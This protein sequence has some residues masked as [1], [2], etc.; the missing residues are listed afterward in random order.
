MIHHET[1][2]DFNDPRNPTDSE[3]R[4]EPTPPME[5]RKL[6]ETPTSAPLPASWSAYY[7]V[8]VIATLL[9][10]ITLFSTRRA[11]GDIT[12][13]PPAPR[14]LDSN[15]DGK[16]DEA[17]LALFTSWFEAG[18][19]R[20]DYDGDGFVTGEDHDQYTKEFSMT[21]GWSTYQLA[22]GAVEF[23]CNSD[24]EWKA[25]WS[26]ADPERGDHILLHAGGTFGSL[27]KIPFGGTISRPMLIGRYGDGPN[28]IVLCHG[29]E[30]GIECTGGGGAPPAYYLA[31][32]GIHFTTD[33]A[34]DQPAGGVVFIRAGRLDVE[35][36]QIE[37][38]SDNLNVRGPVSSPAKLRLHRSFIAGA[39]SRNGSHSQG[40]YVQD[41]ESAE[42]TENT[43][44]HNGWKDPADRTI[45]NHNLYAGTGTRRVVLRSNLSIAA[46]ATGLAAPYE[47][48]IE[49]NL[50]ADCPV[51]MFF[52]PGCSVIN[53]VVVGSGDIDAA[54]PRGM[55]MQLLSIHQAED[56]TYDGP[57]GPARIE[58]NIV[59]NK[60]PGT[61]G[62]GSAFIVNSNAD[63]IRC[64][65]YLTN[66]IGAAWP[67]EP[68][69]L[70]G[71]DVDPKSPPKGDADPISVDG[72]QYAGTAAPI[73]S[74]PDPS[75]NLDAY[76]RS[77]GLRDTQELVDKSRENRRGFWNRALTADAAREWIAQGFS[78]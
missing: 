47:C 71:I 42:I 74:W 40:I 58:G 4:Y 68:D 75:R 21:D 36:C 60:R 72:H 24:A 17:D 65:V 3:S 38:F 20:A 19:A 51:G 6:K 33:R 57:V 26:K 63:G 15:G 27:G 10:I 56:G 50:V 18:D 43:L 41:L 7:V 59:A 29:T 66:N 55:G 46:S 52:R 48:V 16:I 69:V 77:I 67:N 34:G 1:S 13:T 73:S 5:G 30:P 9:L 32:V 35:D 49:G 22:P 76:A 8:L 11:R 45:Y 62:K 14:D 23:L 31:I 70:G 28:P 44:Y 2:R 54:H 53:N 39:Y 61:A 78:R 64:P 37:G 12:P 25:A